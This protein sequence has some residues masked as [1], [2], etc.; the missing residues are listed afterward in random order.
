MDAGRGLARLK[1]KKRRDLFVR[2]MLI[3]IATG[4]VGGG[5]FYAIAYSGL[6]NIPGITPTDRVTSY[7]PPPVTLP[8][9]TPQ[10]AIMSH[11]LLID[12]SFEIESP[13]GLANA[14]RSQLP[15]LLFLIAPLEVDGRLQFALYAGPAYSVEEA[16]AL[17]D[18]IVV[19][20]DRGRTLPMN[21]DDLSVHEA[22]YAF[23][24]GEYPAAVNA[25]GRVDALAGASI[26]AYALQV[27]FADGSTRVRVY[28]GAFS[29]EIEAEE[30]GRMINGA[31]VGAMV[32]T[33]RR[34]TLPGGTLP[35]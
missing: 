24:C 10:T 9:P 1:R 29:D 11:V 8:G 17:R 26:P 6:V 28:G 18:P 22:P 20:L 31:D 34:G 27:A 25:Q 4:A 16:N 5:G 13:L 32:L 23:Y 2:L 7:V 19:V 30:M 12:L 15:N 21:P 35:E 3:V 33:P 14:L